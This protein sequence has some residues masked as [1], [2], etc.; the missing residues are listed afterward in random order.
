MKSFIKNLTPYFILN[1]YYWLMEFL[2]ALWYGFP[3][4]KL[5]VIGVTGTKGKSTTVYFITRILE[6]AGFKATSI[7]SIEF[8]MNK[9]SEQ[10]E[11]KM[12]LPSR[13]ILQKFL[14]KALDLNVDYVILECSSEGLAQ[15]RVDFVHFTG[16][17]FTNLAPEHIES[18]G[19]YETYR[20]AKGRLFQLLSPRGTA[21]LN[22]DDPESQ[23]FVDLFTI[24]RKVPNTIY[25]SLEK[26][27]RILQNIKLKMLGEFNQYNAL[28]AYTVCR[29]LG[30]KEG[31]I[32]SA[33]EKIAFIP[34]RLEEINEG[35]NFRVF[36]DYAHNPS[37]LEA[38][39]KAVSSI[40]YR[41]SRIILVTGSQ[42]GGRDKWKRPEMGKVAAKYA[43]VV[44]VTNEDPYQENP[45]QIINGVYR[46]AIA[47][48]ARGKEQGVRVLKILDRG[49]A[50]RSALR[51]AKKGDIVLIAGKGSE[52]V[53]ETREGKVEWN[54][55]EIVRK[56]LRSLRKLPISNS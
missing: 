40:K 6:E 31:F 28:A 52:T 25:F 56:L 54:E 3:G 5:K 35:Q 42:G 1:T 53:M 26:E 32:R 13:W 18:H 49:E 36:V 50:V 41:V 20:E 44:I 15:H 11:I 16:A 22:Q 24:V 30:V 46:G 51:I 38:V 48:G 27:G 14:K 19:S 17:V 34:G 55:R 12:A 10:N 2:T 47:Q 37:S 23:Y 33:L 45:E 21:V 43:N 4:L 39:L 29:A 9:K 8:R 7:S